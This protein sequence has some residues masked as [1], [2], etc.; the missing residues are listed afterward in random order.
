MALPEQFVYDI[1]PDETGSSQNRN[2][3]GLSP[4]SGEFF[5]QPELSLGMC[6]PTRY[7]MRT[8]GNP[9]GK[10]STE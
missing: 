5:Q 2:S 8:E 4:E 10:I 1:T 7:H 9:F 6:F 3:H